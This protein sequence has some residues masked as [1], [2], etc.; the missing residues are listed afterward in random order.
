MASQWSAERKKPFILLEWYSVLFIWLYVADVSDL[1]FRERNSG[2]AD[3]ATTHSM[4]YS[5]VTI[6]LHVWV[7]ESILHYIVLIGL[8]ELGA[9]CGEVFLRLGCWPGLVQWRLSDA[10][11][12]SGLI[13]CDSVTLLPVVT[14][15]W[16]SY[17]G[18][19]CGPHAFGLPAIVMMQVPGPF[20]GLLILLFI[21][22]CLMAVLLS[23]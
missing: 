6:W 16:W 1:Y 4:P 19:Y 21:L 12:G 18:E 17:G 2:G 13:H 7:L 22:C 14:V 11:D 15:R 8:M 20:D 10:V 23:D 5:A 9:C 3:S